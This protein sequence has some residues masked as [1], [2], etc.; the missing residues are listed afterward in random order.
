[1][2]V[3]TKEDLIEIRTL[4]SIGWK[5]AKI[6]EYRVA[7]NYRGARD[8]KQAGLYK[9]CKTIEAQRGSVE[10]RH[11]SGRPRTARTE[12][13]EERVEELLLSP[14]RQPGAHL[15]HSKTGCWYA[16]CLF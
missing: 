3:F 7:N 5:P 11:G 15:S 1:M 14:E 6:L 10:R 8:W 12:E 13:K 4:L 16:F 2:V 9:A